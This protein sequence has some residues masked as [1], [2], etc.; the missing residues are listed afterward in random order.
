MGD[1]PVLSRPMLPHLWRLYCN[2]N[3]PEKSQGNYNYPEKSQ[4]NYNYP[5]KN[6]GNYNY[7]D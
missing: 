7:P 6:Q 3:Y 5:E 2:Y 4:G 1:K